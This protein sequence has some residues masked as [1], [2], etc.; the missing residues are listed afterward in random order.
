MYTEG[1]ENVQKT[2]IVHLDVHTDSRILRKCPFDP[3]IS[4][5]RC[6]FVEG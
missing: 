3:K 2:N 5:Q 6:L 4:N 1:I